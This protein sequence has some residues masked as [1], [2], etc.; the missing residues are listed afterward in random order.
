M[1]GM[2]IKAVIFDMDGLMFDTERVAGIGMMEALAAQGLAAD[3]AFFLKLLGLNTES[4]RVAL[5]KAF[6]DRI[7]FPAAMA[8]MDGYLERYITEHGT[9]VKPGLFALLERLDERK[10]PRAIASGSPMPRILRNLEMAGLSGRFDAI[11]A[12]DD[13]PRGKPAPDVFL[14]A[15]KALGIEPARCM[16]LEDSA[17]GVEAGKRAGMMTVMVPDLHAPDETD[18]NGLYALA[19]SL[20]DVIPLLD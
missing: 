2:E 6:G 9:P 13:V 10:L 15:A 20:Y 12:A 4:T 18:R 5:D 1:H 11:V 17:A 14:A 16:V 19:Q 3:E 8:G 7:D